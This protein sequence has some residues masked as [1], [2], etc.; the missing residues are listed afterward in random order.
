MFNIGP[1]ELLVIAAVALIVLGP[2]KLPGAMRSVGRVMGELRRI[3][4]GFQD[5]LR[6]ALEDAEREGDDDDDDIRR[7]DRGESELQLPSELPPIE[8]LKRLPS[9]KAEPPIDDDGDS[10]G[11]GNGEA[12]PASE[13]PPSAEIDPEPREAE[14]E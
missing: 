4:G 6:R 11:D 3:S 12:A 10:N 9:V 5:E 1:A 7:A 2:D 13:P 14:A 8:P